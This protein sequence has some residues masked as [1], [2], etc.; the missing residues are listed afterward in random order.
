MVIRHLL[1]Q[2]EKKKQQQE[3]DDLALAP[4][5]EY[6]DEAIESALV[7][8]REDRASN[9]SRR[10]RPRISLAKAIVKLPTKSLGALEDRFWDARFEKRF[11]ERFRHEFLDWLRTAEPYLES[12]E[13]RKLVQHFAKLF[14]DPIQMAYERGVQAGREEL[15]NEQAN[16]RGGQNRLP[17]DGQ[18]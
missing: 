13:P 10:R 11:A 16:A 9:L 2:H 5:R 6:L 7:Q 3:I 15:R 1:I 8:E 18:G 4:Y 17:K 12:H 14:D